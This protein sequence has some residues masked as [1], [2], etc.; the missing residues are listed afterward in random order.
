MLCFDVCRL[1]LQ[2]TDLRLLLDAYAW[3]HLADVR[4][5]LM[6]AEHSQGVNA[7]V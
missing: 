1:S 5:V 6:H 2:W 7:N 4:Q 3:A